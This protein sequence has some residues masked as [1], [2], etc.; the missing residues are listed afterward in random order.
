MDSLFDISIAAIQVWQLVGDDQHMRN[1]LR[2]IAP[3]RRGAIHTFGARKLVPPELCVFT[4]IQ[5]V[6]AW[7]VRQ[8]RDHC[9]SFSNT[10]HQRECGNVMCGIT[11]GKLVP[12]AD[13]DVVLGK[14]ELIMA[15]VDTFKLGSVSTHFDAGAD[16]LQARMRAYRWFCETWFPQM[17]HKDPRCYEA[18]HKVGILTERERNAF[19][20]C[21]GV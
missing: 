5:L 8:F 1:V 13:F 2:N 4:D 20:A 15:A 11:G 6:S 14:F 7:R 9:G 16:A 10:A 18:A 12:T 19:M 17:S 3:W 21:T